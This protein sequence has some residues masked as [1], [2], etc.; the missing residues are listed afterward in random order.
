MSD[1]LC[2]VLH[3]VP[4]DADFVQLGL[5]VIFQPCKQTR[6]KLPNCLCKSAKERGQSYPIVNASLQETRTKSPNCRCT[7][8][9]R[10]GQSYPAVEASLQADEKKVTHMLLLILR[11]RRGQSHSTFS[12]LLQADE[13]KVTQQFMKVCEQ[14]RTNHTKSQCKSTSRQGQIYPTVS[15]YL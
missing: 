3:H 1:L 10:R 11:A 4:E 12:A 6:T 8:E 14:I 9:S 13:G 2:D 7:S 15:A 5:H